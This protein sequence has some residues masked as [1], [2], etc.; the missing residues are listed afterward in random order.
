MFIAHCIE[1]GGRPLAGDDETRFYREWSDQQ[2]L[3]FKQYW[4]QWTRRNFRQ[5]GVAW[6]A[7]WLSAAGVRRR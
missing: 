3:V 2:R 7:W 1:L 5:L 6:R 4:F